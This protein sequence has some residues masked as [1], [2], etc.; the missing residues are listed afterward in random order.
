[1]L[2]NE[3]R[4]E[5]KEKGKETHSVLYVLVVPTVPFIVPNPMVPEGTV[6]TEVYMDSKVC[7][8]ATE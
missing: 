3:T 7:I 2:K 5:K 1:M 6:E 8:Q 4:K